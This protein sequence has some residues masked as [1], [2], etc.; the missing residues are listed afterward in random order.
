M[1][2]W[3]KKKILKS[4]IN[5]L[6]NEIPELKVTIL[7]EFEEHKDELLEKLQEVI[8]KAIKDFVASKINR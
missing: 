8:K 3:I 2:K 1:F 7:E 4:I 6:K 5:D